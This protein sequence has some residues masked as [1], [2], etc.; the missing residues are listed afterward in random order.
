M[1]N[2]FF[3]FNFLVFLTIFIPIHSQAKESEFLCSNLFNEEYQPNVRINIVNNLPPDTTTME[4]TEKNKSKVSNGESSN[5]RI[6]ITKNK[7][8]KFRGYVIII[9]AMAGASALSIIINSNLPSNLLFVS[10]F[11]GNLSALLTVGMAA[12]IWSP[13]LSRYRQ[14][15][16]KLFQEEKK[17][18]VKS[19]YLDRLYKQTQEA[20]SVDQQMARNV[21]NAALYTFQPIVLEAR[22]GNMDGNTNFAVGLLADMAVR[23][24]HLFVEMEPDDPYFTQ[25]FKVSFNQEIQDPDGFK[26][27]LYMR[28]SQFDSEI[29]NNSV[30]EYYLKLINSWL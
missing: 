16:F 22:R 17:P 2:N 8:K 19:S 21:I 4:L 12:P 26:Q 9:S 13:L 27:M 3:K 30:A 11:I 23:L 10:P 24:R 6:I 7:F 20:L 1:L 15:G 5:N 14:H 28:I 29:S 18:I 25:M